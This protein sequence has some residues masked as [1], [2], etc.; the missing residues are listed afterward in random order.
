M[1]IVSLELKA[2]ADIDICT[3]IC[4]AAPPVTET[5]ENDNN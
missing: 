5:R 4:I 2:R 1:L 3:D